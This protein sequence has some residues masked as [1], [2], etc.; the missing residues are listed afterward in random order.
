MIL[1]RWSDYRTYLRWGIPPSYDWSTLLDLDFLRG[2]VRSLGGN[3]EGLGV[4][5]SYT[6][7]NIIDKG[8]DYPSSM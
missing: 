5:I 3:T 6:Y 7:G 2:Y 1:G 4:G 8:I